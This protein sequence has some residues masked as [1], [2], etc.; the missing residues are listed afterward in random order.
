[1]LNRTSGGIGSVETYTNTAFAAKL[2]A[3]ANR[4]RRN[5]VDFAD[6]NKLKSIVSE[7]GFQ[8][9]LERYPTLLQNNR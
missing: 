9:Y 7:K 6:I 5:L 3:L 2:A 8:Y 1:M 4:K